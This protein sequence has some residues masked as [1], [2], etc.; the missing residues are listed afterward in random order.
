MGTQHF[1]SWGLIQQAFLPLH[2]NQPCL[3][4]PS[5]FSALTPSVV[6]GVARWTGQGNTGELNSHF[7]GRL[8]RSS[9]SP[10]TQ[11]AVLG[12]ARLRGRW[13]GMSRGTPQLKS[14][15]I[16]TALKCEK[17]IKITYEPAGFPL[18]KSRAGFWII[19]SKRSIGGSELAS[20]GDCVASDWRGRRGEGTARRCLVSEVA[21]PGSAGQTQAQTS[22]RCWEV[23]F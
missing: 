11:L 20:G 12:M 6:S 17:Y 22:S 2:R 21:A 15:V 13:Q 19:K 4:A 1:I 9:I 14:S 18:I 10:S 3:A 16:L 7:S 5:F 8:L 23:L